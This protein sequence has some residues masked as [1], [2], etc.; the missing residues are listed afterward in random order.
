MLVND[1]LHGWKDMLGPVSHPPHTMTL[2]ES[3][4]S[5][6]PVMLFISIVFCLVE[7][8]SKETLDLFEGMSRHLPV[9]RQLYIA[10]VLAR[11]VSSLTEVLDF[12]LES[13]KV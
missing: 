1:R 11:T 7:A 2:Q 10:L 3:P 4:T 5:S 13:T 9:R 8:P 6:C 12:C